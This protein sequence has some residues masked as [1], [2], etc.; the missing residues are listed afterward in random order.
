MIGVNRDQTLEEKIVEKGS[1]FQFILTPAG[2][3]A[4]RARIVR[5]VIIAFSST[6]ATACVLTFKQIDFDTSRQVAPANQG[7][8]YPQL[9]QRSKIWT[10]LD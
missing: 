9:L 3:S 2:S 7:T 4:T 1:H 8:G 6:Y 5:T 10:R